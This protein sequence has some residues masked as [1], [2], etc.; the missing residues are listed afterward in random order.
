M[1]GGVTSTN[2]GTPLSKK[3]EPS[4]QTNLPSQETTNMDLQPTDTNTGTI[5]N[6]GDGN[7][8]VGSKQLD[9]K[10][11]GV[12]DGVKDKGGDGK[13]EEGDK[14]ANIFLMIGGAL[15]MLTCILL[16]FFAPALGIAAFVPALEGAAVTGGVALVGGAASKLFKEN[17]DSNNEVD[18]K[19]PRPDV[20]KGR[21]KE[22]ETGLDHSLATNSKDGKGPGHKVDQ[23]SGQSNP[24]GAT[25]EQ[26][27]EFDINHPFMTQE[28]EKAARVEALKQAIDSGIMRDLSS[29]TAEGGNEGTSPRA[30][31]FAASGQGSINMN[32]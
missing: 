25:H 30:P 31:T 14:A 22:L 4:S 6:K 17:P 18:N 32:R 8:E 2:G 11:K 23:D 28:D 9:E 21:G 12:D 1:G 5:T 24:Y 10:N 26:L 19:S 16:I 20:E 15:L 13:E 7:K 3:V 29:T 27:K